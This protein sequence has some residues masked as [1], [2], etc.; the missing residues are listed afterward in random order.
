[1]NKNVTSEILKE[2]KERLSTG[3]LECNMRRWFK[4]TTKL[5]K[6]QS[7]EVFN[8]TKREILNQDT[9]INETSNWGQELDFNGEVTY[10]K[11]LDVYILFLNKLNKNITLKGE[12]VRDIQRSFSDLLGEPA[13]IN[14]LARA[15]GIPR[16]FLTEIIKKLG[17]THSELPLTEEEIK[18]KSVE[19]ISADLLELKKF[20][21]VQEFN[22]KD[23]RESA[24]LAN[25]WREFQ[26]GVL[27][28]FE[29]YI[30][31]FDFKLNNVKQKIVNYDYSNDVIL[32]SANDWQIGNKADGRFLVFGEEWNTEKCFNA[33]ETVANKVVNR[34]K[35]RNIDKL[36]LLFNGDINHGF[37]GRTTKGTV[38]KC[39]TFK[40]EQFDATIKAISILISNCADHFNEIN[41]YVGTG[42]HEGWTFYPT[43]KLIQ[44]IFRDYDFVKFHLSLKD[45]MF[46]RVNNSMIIAHHGAAAE[47][48]F[49]VPQD[50]KGRVAFVQKLIRIAS[51]ELKFYEP[52]RI[53]FIKGDT[54]AFESADLGQF[55]FFTFGALPKG[56]EFANALNLEGTPTQNALVISDNKDYE[57]WHLTF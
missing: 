49:K 5:S 36:T 1:M 54:H 3:E 34:A 48:D 9:L 8:Q 10:N 7:N 2:F 42:N 14:E 56:D 12:V 29:Q 18:D 28:P 11:D 15:H 31:K 21:I 53:F 30:S 50:K 35:S 51:K 17:L 44:E 20:K 22:K 25:K 33:I 6:S 32:L 57:T 38:L 4:H 24:H 55:T 52:E 23:W 40:Y 37:E 43:F 16:H 13:T 47:Y 27:D 41:C 46:F 45:S 19:D 26:V 39:D